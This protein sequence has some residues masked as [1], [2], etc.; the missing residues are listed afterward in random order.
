MCHWS[1]G[2]KPSWKLKREKPE[3]AMADLP[4]WLDRRDV[5]SAACY[6]AFEELA[7]RFPNAFMLLGL[8]HLHMIVHKSPDWFETPDSMVDQIRCPDAECSRCRLR[9]GGYSFRWFHHLWTAK[10]CQL[11]RPGSYPPAHVRNWT[12]GVEDGSLQLIYQCIRLDRDIESQFTGVISSCV[13]K[14][15]SPGVAANTPTHD[16]AL[17]T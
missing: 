12:V 16:S 10:Y 13:A 2:A 11:Q 1:F 17:I 14:P 7:L 6:S 15:T 3:G 4:K 9:L 8:L 5:D